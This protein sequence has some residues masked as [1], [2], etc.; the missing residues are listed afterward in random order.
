[1][2]TEAYL[3]PCQTSI[4]KLFCGNSKRLVPLNSFAK[5]LSGL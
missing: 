4:M 1:M 2:F 5:S 3:E